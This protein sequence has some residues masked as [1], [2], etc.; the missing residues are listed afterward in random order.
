MNWLLKQGHL[1]KESGLIPCLQE[2]QYN[3]V[4]EQV[5]QERSHCPHIC[6]EFSKYLN[7]IFKFKII[8]KIKTKIINF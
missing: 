7:K 6:K 2:V 8:N 5:K 1:L 4:D 3:A